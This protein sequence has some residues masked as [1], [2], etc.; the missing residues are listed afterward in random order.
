MKKVLNSFGII[1]SGVLSICLFAVLIAT[2]L[3]HMVN[4]A[5]QPGTIKKI[6]S[7]ID[8]IELALSNEDLREELSNHGIDAEFLEEIKESEILSVG[9]NSYIEGLFE[10]KGFDKDTVLQMIE[11]GQDEAVYY[12]KG[13]SERLGHKLH[14][15]PDAEVKE[16]ILNSVDEKWDQLAAALPTPEDLGISQEEYNAMSLMGDAVGGAEIS[17]G[18][19]F[20]VFYDGAI[21]SAMIV[22]AAI[23]S[24]LILLFRFP[25]F[26]GFI[27]LFVLYLISAL[28]TFGVSLLIGAF[29]LSIIPELAQI[30]GEL[31]A[32]IIA[33]MAGSIQGGAWIL[34]G[35]SLLWIAVFI[36]AAILKKVHSRKNFV[37]SLEEELF[38]DP[39]EAEEVEEPQTSDETVDDVLQMA[40]QFLSETES[41]I[42]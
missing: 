30:Q 12:I 8:F 31:I 11:Q 27:W 9:V 3:L 15:L 4:S 38:D 40:D 36:S 2:P 26:K 13:L 16:I 5:F 32:P 7:E 29:D 22:V 42:Q 17:A 18:Q 1:I 37:P 28:L 41:E 21:V 6:I 34:L 20:K 23:L 14:E 10:G 25:K 39:G 19:M 35:L 33:V 24:V